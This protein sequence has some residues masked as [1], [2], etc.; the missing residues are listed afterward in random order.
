M[1]FTW[2]QTSL[3]DV[4]FSSDSYFHRALKLVSFGVFIGFAI[5][6]PIFDTGP[7]FQDA[8]AFKAMSLILMTSRLAIM[9]Q[10]A[11]VLWYVRGYKKVL[12]PL[13][14]HIGIMFVSAMSFLG[15]SFSFRYETEDGQVLYKNLEKIT[16]PSYSYI[17]W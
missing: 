11:V 14:L 17:G 5:V 3:V 1:W 4:R 9:V 2:L 16:S 13:L 15:L 7:A 8:K 6:G 10:Y 12:L